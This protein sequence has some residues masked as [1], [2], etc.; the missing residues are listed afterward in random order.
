MNKHKTEQKYLYTELLTLGFE[1]HLIERA[2]KM[3]N[4]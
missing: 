4:D 2:L 1:E 3:T